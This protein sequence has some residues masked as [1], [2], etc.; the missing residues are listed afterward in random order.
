MSKFV[1]RVATALFA[2]L[3]FGFVAVPLASAQEA[4]AETEF[5]A[6]WSYTIESSC[7]GWEGVIRQGANYWGGASEG[8]GT[9]VRC[10]NSAITDCGFFA[11]GVETTDVHGNL[12]VV[13]CNYGMGQLIKLYPG[14]VNDP[15]LLAAHEFGHNWYGHS[16]NGCASWASPT[17]VMATTM[18]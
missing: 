8:G 2:A 18:C 12:I 16:Y 15:A 9:P 13:G 14:A 1:M 4:P 7:A 3:A 6:A 5:E 10:Q 17:D 11:E